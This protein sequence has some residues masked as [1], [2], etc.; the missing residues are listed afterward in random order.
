[1]N[2]FSESKPGWGVGGGNLFIFH[3]PYFIKSAEEAKCSGKTSFRSQ[4]RQRCT[5]AGWFVSNKRKKP[6][7]DLFC[8]RYKQ[9]NPFLQVILYLYLQHHQH[10]I[11]GGPGASPWGA[12]VCA[13]RRWRF[14]ARVLLNY[15]C[16]CVKHQHLVSLKPLMRSWVT[17]YNPVSSFVPATTC[18]SLPA[19]CHS[20]K[21]RHP[22]ILVAV[23]HCHLSEFNKIIFLN[24]FRCH[25]YNP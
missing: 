13:V 24:C 16:G 21:L 12:H 8:L 9:Q 20:Q 17:S 25:I 19:S 14:G 22:G 5:T 7:S 4:P 15:S 10:S 11:K 6:N 3:K 18:S 23:H 1:M 2:M